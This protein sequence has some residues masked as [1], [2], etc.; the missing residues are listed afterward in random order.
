MRREKDE[1]ERRLRRSVAA[2]HLHVTRP[3]CLS[4]E[5]VLLLSGWK[6]SWALDCASVTAVAP[7]DS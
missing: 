4:L 1:V 5:A 3:L 7:L 6:P 2:A